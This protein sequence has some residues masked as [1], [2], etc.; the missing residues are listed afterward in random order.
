MR[1]RINNLE[2]FYAYRDAYRKARELEKAKIYVCCGTGC[3]ASGGLKVF[4]AFKERL[5]ALK[6]PCAGGAC[7]GAGRGRCRR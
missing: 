1:T 6:V 5:A 3:V 4:E 2:E 7:A